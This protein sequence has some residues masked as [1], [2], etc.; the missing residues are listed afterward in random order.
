M[1][2]LPSNIEIVKAFKDYCKGCSV[3]ELEVEE[4]KLG[5]ILNTSQYFLRCKHNGAC[6]RQYKLWKTKKGKEK[7]SGL[8]AKS[9]IIDDW[10]TEDSEKEKENGG[11]DNG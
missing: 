10:V 5:N 2:N 3:C 8:R 4:I 11:T 7:I 9:N 1:D 6:G